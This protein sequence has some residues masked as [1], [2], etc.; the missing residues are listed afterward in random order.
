[1]LGTVEDYEEIRQLI[2]SYCHMLDTHDAVGWAALFSE[3]G[4]LDLG[5]AKTQGTD[6]L[7]AYIEDLRAAHRGYPMRHLV[8]NVVIDV[9]GDVAASQSY[10]VLLNPGGPRLIGMT[11][12]YD[13]QLR[14]IDGRWRLLERR[15]VC[16][17]TPLGVPAVL[18]QLPA[19]AHRAAR[20]RYQRARQSI[21]A[22]R[23]PFVME[24]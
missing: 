15:L 6:A 3:D 10:V 12:R 17:P 1:M 18:R 20:I 2:A 5:G 16:D 24:P 21:R 11:G 23:D 7:Q 4:M 14:R 19:M 13:D 8:T 9:D 22:M